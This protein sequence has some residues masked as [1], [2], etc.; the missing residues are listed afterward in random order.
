MV[1]IDGKMKRVLIVS[2]YFPPSALPPAQR[3]RL[4]VKNLAKQNYY[5]TVITVEQKY[6]E[7]I[8]DEW[9]TTLT[10]NDYKL[11]NLKAIP[12][13]ITR[14]FKFG[15]LGLRVLP[16]LFFN[17]LKTIRREKPDIVLYLVPSW[18]VLVISPVIKAITKTPYIIDFIDPWVS[19]GID[20][21]RTIKHKISQKIAVFFEKRAVLHAAGIIAVSEGINNKIINRY[22]K[23]KNKF[24]K[25][26]PYGVEA[27]D[28]KIVQRSNEAK[29]KIKKVRYIGAVW[30]D[31]LPVLGALLNAFTQSGE[32]LMLEFYGTSYAPKELSTP[33]LTPFMEK[34]PKL[35]DIL[36]E[37]H[38]RV[39]YRKA[40]ELT[41]SS[42]WL[43]L[44]GGMEPYYAA[45]KLFGLIASQVPFL[46]F[47]HQD[48][49]PAQFLS[50]LNYP[51]L[52]TYSHSKTPD[53]CIGELIEKIKI[54]N[55]N[56]EKQILALNH[57]AIK[58]HS[59]ENMTK[60]FVSLFNKCIAQNNG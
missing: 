7:G 37:N 11:I 23:A 15:D 2:P 39:P 41:V 51:Y 21:S 50:T 31:A 10:G 42:D 35:K 58:N 30:N 34:N 43:I 53:K 45:S 18:Y 6:R 3:A 60:E 16:Y 59:A 24:F 19:S 14:K 33:Q 26:V 57:P 29:D 9:L 17:L 47:L 44:F 25:A 52:V 12:Y 56:Q 1:K 55:S 13:Q 27:D 28:F 54:L 49:F 22:P 36:K 32:K 20:S 46:A 5:P 4:L 8:T 38:L 40:V 48:S